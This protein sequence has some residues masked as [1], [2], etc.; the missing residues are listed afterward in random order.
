MGRKLFGAIGFL[1]G[2]T[3]NIMPLVATVMFIF[4]VG[5]PAAADPLV[6]S[7]DKIA[8][9]GHSASSNG[10]RPGG[11]ITLTLLGLK[12]VG[13]EATAINAGQEGYLSKD[14]LDCLDRDVISKKPDWLVLSCGA[15]DAWNC[16]SGPSPLLPE[17][18]VN[19]TKIVE[20]AQAANI[21]VMILTETSLCRDSQRLIP[22]NE[23]L[24]PLAT[25]KKC[26]F[27]DIYGSFQETLKANP[28]TPLTSDG[29]ADPWT[30]LAFDGC[31][32]NAQG[33]LV[34]ANGVLKAFGLNDEQMAKAEKAIIDQP[35]TFEGATSLKM[36]FTLRQI[37]FL[38]EIAAKNKM[39][40]DQMISLLFASDIFT[41]APIKTRADIESF[42]DAQR[43][44]DPWKEMQ[45]RLNQRLNTLMNGK[46]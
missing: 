5:F 13:I 23:F 3:R 27:A 37:K 18:K 42:L 29:K 30:P 22:F 28:W 31:N 17:F 43:N 24:R 39:S 8:F 1:T 12:A 44:K 7:G 38:D 35:D 6:K 41:D 15:G 9:L 26:V 45:D 11:Y 14:M 25:E 34:M 20:K 4:S 40:T 46:E 10:V 19:I 2:F 33:F 21:K 36:G 16:W 32:P